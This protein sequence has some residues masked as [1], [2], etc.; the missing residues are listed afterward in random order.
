MNNSTPELIVEVLNVRNVSGLSG[1]DVPRSLFLA[2]HLTLEEI[3]EN[4]KFRF[5]CLIA[6]RLDKFHSD[7]IIV[8]ADWKLGISSDPGI[9]TMLV[10]MEPKAEG[11]NYHLVLIKGDISIKDDSPNQTELPQQF[12]FIEGSTNNILDDGQTLNKRGTLTIAKKILKSDPPQS[13]DQ[14]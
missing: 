6:I 13:T 8:T 11:A 2:P 9:K 3:E 5:S 14:S 12:F 10:S 7:D 4:R 1:D